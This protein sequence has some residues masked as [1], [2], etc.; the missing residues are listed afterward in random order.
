MIVEKLKLFIPY[1]LIRSKYIY[2]GSC[3]LYKVPLHSD[4]FYSPGK[5]SCELRSVI[6]IRKELSKWKKYYTIFHELGHHLIWIVGGRSKIMYIFH[7]IWDLIGVVFK[8]VLEMILTIIRNTKEY[9]VVYKK[10]LRY[11]N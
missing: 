11:N 4:G 6:L 7:I 10:L 9:F 2:D 5:F 1:I 3:E 8:A